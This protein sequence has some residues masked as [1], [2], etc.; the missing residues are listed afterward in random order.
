VRRALLAFG[1]LGLTLSLPTRV[2][3]SDPAYEL[4]SEV[5]AGQSSGG[6]ACGPKATARYGGVGARV[7]VAQGPADAE[8]GAGLYATL[9]AVGEYE[10]VEITSCEE[11]PCNAP[12]DHLMF[13]RGVGTGFRTRW[14]GV[15][16][17]I[18]AFQDWRNNTDTSP[19]W[20]SFPAFELSFGKES[21]FHWPLGFG[22]PFVSAY[23]HP[24]VL[25]T[26]PR[27]VAR[28]WRLELLGGFYRAG[29]TRSSHLRFDAAAEFLI[30]ETLW[31]GP[32]AALSTE[33]PPLDGEI[34]LRVGVDL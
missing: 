22:A 2:I 13:G 19:D 20:S 26:G 33:G 7:R 3:A 10:Y 9:G 17:G 8:D 15:S 16:I 1:G 29:P 25:Y 6:W 18:L 23:R 31:L 5:Y 28:A 34:G 14:V 21:D 27:Y 32:H 12:P 4:D 30:A 24:A 11:A